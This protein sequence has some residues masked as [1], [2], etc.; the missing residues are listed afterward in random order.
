MAYSRKT[1]GKNL[2]KLNDNWNDKYWIFVAGGTLTLMRKK[3]GQR[4][5]LPNY[6]C[7]PKYISQAYNDIEADGGDW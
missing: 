7:D 6:G 5:I 4:A 2:Q 3:K 1:I